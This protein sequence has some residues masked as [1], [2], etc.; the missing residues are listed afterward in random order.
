MLPEETA[1]FLSS[2]FADV[3]ALKE[4]TVGYSCSDAL[5]LADAC[6]ISAVLSFSFRMTVVL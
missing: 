1:A 3:P 6:A 2:L 4:V 5:N